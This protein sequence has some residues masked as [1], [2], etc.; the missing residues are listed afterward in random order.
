L[1]TSPANTL[2]LRQ[3]TDPIVRKRVT[4]PRDPRAVPAADRASPHQRPANPLA[5]EEV[6]KRLVDDEP[7][8]EYEE[9]EP[10]A[11]EDDDT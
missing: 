6:V 11:P 2:A 5:T 3:P 9:G 10:E 1:G 8:D 4:V 7:T